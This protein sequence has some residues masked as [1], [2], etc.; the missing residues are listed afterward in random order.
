MAKVQVIFYSMYGHVYQ[1]A[2]AIA[3]GAREVPSADVQVF[4]VPELVPEEALIASGAK[5][6]RDNFF[7]YPSCRSIDSRRSRC[8]H[9]RYAYTLWQ[10]VRPDAQLFRSKHSVMVVWSFDR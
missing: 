2:E 10:Y 7:P 3:E 5:A 9:I 8:H 1:L 4:Q 6:A